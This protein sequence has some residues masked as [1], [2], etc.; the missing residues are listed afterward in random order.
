M[1]TNDIN[2]SVDDRPLDSG[3]E[4]IELVLEHDASRSGSDAF[5]DILLAGILVAVVTHLISDMVNA[6]EL[7]EQI[8]NN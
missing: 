5:M 1:N 4:S 2:G 6:E 8:K 7:E 3:D